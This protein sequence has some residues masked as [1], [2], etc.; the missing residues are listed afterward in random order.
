MPFLAS[1]GYETYS[2]SLRGT[3]GTLI[4]GT[5]VRWFDAPCPDLDFLLCCELSGGRCCTSST[6]VNSVGR[7][8]G[9]LP[10]TLLPLFASRGP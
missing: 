7:R 9:V 4:P 8:H 3:S 1:K 10:P 5:E 2:I 6:A